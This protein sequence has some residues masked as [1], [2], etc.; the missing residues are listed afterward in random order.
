LS[1]ADQTVTISGSVADTLRA[2]HT[3]HVDLLLIHNATIET[4]KR[5][6]VIGELHRL[7]ETGAVRY[8]GASFYD[9]EAVLLAI[10]MGGYDCV[11]IA[12]S[13]LDR[14]PEERI[15]ETA[16]KN[17]VGVM[18]RSVLLKGALTHRSAN[19][20]PALDKLRTAVKQLSGALSA[21]HERLPE[22]A[23]R[24]VLGNPLI[25]TALAGTGQV[26]ELLQI[27]SFATLGPLTKT[28]QDA[29]QSVQVEPEWLLDPSQWPQ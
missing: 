21:G 4:V 12:Y 18:I 2:L 6:E 17:D 11:Q 8:V 25:G 20:H 26:K 7:R 1:G 10:E 19:L 23:Y 13:M 22:I 5:G 29:I 27:I 15:I 9:E 14:R 24:Y 3:D 28:E 16:A